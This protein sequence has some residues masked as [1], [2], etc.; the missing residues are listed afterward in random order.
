MATHPLSQRDRA[1]YLDTLAL[2]G[3]TT[4]NYLFLWDLQAGLLYFPRP[5]HEK[6]ALPA[7]V[8]GRHRIQDLYAAVCSQDLPAFQETLA[9][10]RQG[11]L[12][13]L[14]AEYRLT[15]VSGNQ[16]WT[17]FHGK[18][19]VG[20]DG[21]PE[22]LTGWISDMVLELKADPLTGLLNAEKA[23]EDMEAHLAQN[24]RGCFLLLDIDD[25]TRFNR[26]HGKGFGN[27]ILRQICALLEQLVSP[28]VRIYRIESDCFAVDLIGCGETEAN[29]LFTRIL[30]EAAPAY[31]LSAGASLYGDG[32]AATGDMVRQYAENA[33]DR[34]K[35]QGPGTLLFSSTEDYERSVSSID[36]QQELRQ[37]IETG[38]RGLYLC[39]QPQISSQTYRA[40]GAEAL[41]RYNSPSRG[42]VSP[43]EFVPIL[44]Q[45]GMI[46]AVGEWVLK[47]ALAQCALWRQYIPQFHISIN[48]SYVQLRKKD[49]A[50]TVL[51]LLE[52]SGLPGSALTLEVTESMQLQDAQYFNRLFYQWQNAGIQISIDDFGSGYSSLNYL[53]SIEVDETKIDRC[54]VSR[55]QHSAY[56]Y[57]LLSNM[58]QLA[59][60]AKIKVCCEGVETEEELL[61]L[62]ELQ[63]DLLQG[64][65]FS[66]PYEADRFEDA[67]IRTDSPAYQTRL[68][69]EGRL[70]TLEQSLARPFADVKSAEGPKDTQRA[71]AAGRIADALDEIIYVCG[72]DNFE[73]Y[74]LNP[75]G[76]ALT[77]Q[78]DYRGRKC[79][80]VLYGQD[81]PCPFC[82]LAAGGEDPISVP[83]S[84]VEEVDNPFL[85]RHFIVK[86]KTIPWQ[87]GT[88]RL[89]VAID[90]TEKEL[91]TRGVQQQL[92]SEQLIT[93]SSKA[94]I[95]ETDL[96]K[97]IMQVLRLIGC[98]Y[99]ADRVY[100]AQPT[101]DGSMWH[102]TNIWRREGLLP[103]GLGR[104][105]LSASGLQPWIQK[106]SDGQPVVLMD[107]DPLKQ[108]A[109][110]VWDLLS[111]RQVR[112]MFGAAILKEQKI[113]GFLNVE[114][115]RQNLKRSPQLTALSG[116]LADRLTKSD[117]EKRLNELLSCRY[118]DILQNTCLGLWVIRL[119]RDKQRFEM[120]VDRI[121]RQILAIPENAGPQECYHHWYD[122]INDGYFHYVNLAIES[123]IGSRNI[124]EMEYTWNHPEKGEVM[125]R[126][127]GLRAA[128]SEGC[129]YLE[130]YQR[131]LSGM[132]R[133]RF[134]PDGTSS[135]MFEYNERK[136]SI[137][138]HTG[139]QIL[140]GEADREDDFPEC[141][142]RSGIV[143]P[144]FAEEFRALFVHLEKKED[145]LGAEFLLRAKNGT[146]EWFKLKT[147]HIGQDEQD[148]NTIIV[149]IDPAG[150]ERAME[151]E[152]MRKSDFYKAM[153]SETAAY[154]E[155]DVESGLLQT[156]G[157]L[158]AP[159]VE[160]CQR[161]GLPFSQTVDPHIT[162]LVHAEQADHYRQLLSTQGMTAIARDG[163]ATRTLSFQRKVGDGYRW[164]KL[165]IHI[166][167]ERFSENLYA[168]LYLKDI[169]EEKKRELAQEAAASHD[170]LTGVYNRKA[171]SDQVIGYMTEETAPSG[172]LAILD[173]DDFKSIND[174]YGHLEG[175][176]A[177][178][179]LTQ[180]LQATFRRRD[181]IGRLGGDEFLVFIK[182][183]TEQKILDKRMEHLYETLHKAGKIPLTCSVGIAL[184]HPKDF[185]YEKSLEQADHALYYSKEHGK[186]RYT[187]FHDLTR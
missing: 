88:A 187:Y 14:K 144:H 49:I 54:F 82:A 137:Y 52:E 168:L 131:V 142:I 33:L 107:I 99:N 43:G 36:L 154:A 12:P 26:K 143:H 148:L 152:Y 126:S 184:V 108:T 140:A 27:H 153:L 3:E 71:D 72:P 185:S 24:A 133:P 178:K 76:R 96:N 29:T 45:T 2:L 105:L 124:V 115:P 69:K 5:I 9:A 19:Q 61:A 120:F 51:K 55:I 147:R 94:L 130:G 125:V 68:Q 161:S 39:Y 158:W 123:M 118:E 87:G 15:D 60:S 84:Q 134:L 93:A 80:K 81:D 155:V 40:T 98:F 106:A 172:A 151:L 20:E 163:D 53:K 129:I 85:K 157:G 23:K 63:P 1:N 111:K 121:M 62:Q 47:T 145:L 156:A 38:F 34:A 11:R 8:D 104:P 57:R 28:S 167:K 146:Y 65:L 103:D 41:L 4:P 165:V 66:E 58:I 78:Q 174:T 175:D 171:F 22:L 139:R 18:V 86:G 138:F 30:K 182:D 35:R 75:A 109:P 95:E 136:G 169:N 150:Q 50:E 162:E 114:D 119:D 164:M 176:N 180:V 13:T 70:H 110:Q 183:V 90:L 67:Y 59:H 113:L 97:A 170:P 25:F 102:S 79:Y 128:D 64:Y 21:R 44:E 186:D 179:T 74:Y 135:E 17:S 112:R 122:R 56:N 127:L 177:L 7:P 132:E 92:D 160:E 181:I 116:L 91:A 83:D 32:R 16:I 89:G 73:L 173:L 10:V 101:P 166:F 46:C 6:Y 149:L 37:S 100:L 141:W 42:N 159:Y 117:T 77:G 31:T 48:L